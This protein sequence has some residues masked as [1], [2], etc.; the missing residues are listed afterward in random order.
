MPRMDYETFG[1]DGFDGRG[2]TFVLSGLSENR[3]KQVAADIVQIGGSLGEDIVPGS[4]LVVD[5]AAEST[6]LYEEALRLTA[7]SGANITVM[8]LDS[9][10]LLTGHLRDTSAVAFQPCEVTFENDIEGDA[11][12]VAAAFRK[13]FGQIACLPVLDTVRRQLRYRI[14]FRLDLY[15]EQW[16]A[17]L[18]FAA[19]L[20]R[21]PFR[22]THEGSYE[23]R[24][25][26]GYFV[27]DT[28][29]FARDLIPL[30][31]RSNNAGFGGV[32]ENRSPAQLDRYL[33]L[34]LRCGSRECTA[35]VLELKTRLAP[36]DPLAGL[37][38]DLGPSG[39][40][41]EAEE[42]AA[43]GI[44]F[45]RCAQGPDG[46][47]CPVVWD[48]LCRKDGRALLLS[49]YGLTARPFHAEREPVNWSASTLRAWL[50]STFL[51]DVF[52]EEER[53]RIC[54]TTCTNHS[55]PQFGIDGGPPTQD[56]IFLLS[57]EEAELAF[58]RETDRILKPTPW[59]VENGAW[60]NAN[61]AGWWWL[62]SPGRYPTFA[63]SVNTDGTLR[64]FGNGVIDP[65]IVVRPALWI[66]FGTPSSEQAGDTP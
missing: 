50:N 57:L 30:C 16:R 15:T 35:A 11:E 20:I 28:G 13:E 1:L 4:V 37:S 55:N 19:R 9:F 27:L 3:K 6:E 54:L 51:E 62:R 65:E 43:G 44:V 63:A 39:L 18:R 36:R 48:V 23:A 31:I 40:S 24:A 60:K 53:A 38:L 22:L 8:H 46:A 42:D 33:E 32:I 61:G 47:V 58:D 56:R 29:A 34:S 59:A 49:R 41:A 52:S 25:E 14:R 64:D 66:D 10:F 2:K 12:A 7:E 21:H 26:N 45:G 17:E 5:P